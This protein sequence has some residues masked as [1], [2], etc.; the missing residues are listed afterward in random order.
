MGARKVLF[1]EVVNLPDEPLLKAT[2]WAGFGSVYWVQLTDFDARDHMIS[3]I[4]LSRHL[5]R[6][7]TP[8]FL[9]LVGNQ[10]GQA[11]ME[12]TTGLFTPE[13]LIQNVFLATGVEVL[14][15]QYSGDNTAI[16]F[17]SEAS[18][19]IGIETGI[20]MSTGFANTADDQNNSG[21]TSG[22]T[23]Q[24]NFSD[25]DLASLVDPLSVGDLSIF[26][27]TFIPLADSLEFSYV[28]ASEEYEEYVCTQFNDVFGFFISGPGFAGPFTDGAENIAL[29][30]GTNDFVAIGTVNNG[31]P[32]IPPATC[33][34]QN[35]NLFNVTPPNDQPQFDGYTDVFVARA[36]VVPCDTYKIRITIADASDFIFDSGVFL[37]AKSFGTPTVD[38]AIETVAPN[39]TIAE[40]CS[41]GN[42]VFT[43]RNPAATDLDIPIQFIGTATP[44]VD[45]SMTPPTIQIPQGETEVSTQFDVF[46]D[47]VLE[48]RES[49][50]MVIQRD[51]CK[52]DTIW[53]FIT[54]DTLPKPDLGPDLLV[55][56]NDDV[57]LDGTLPV[58]LPEPK[59]F[60][61][62][63]S[64]F[65]PSPPDNSSPVTPVYSPLTV[66]GVFPKDLGPGMI[67]SVCVNI[68]HKWIDDVDIYLIAPSGRFV[69]LSS[70]NG[71]DGDNYTETCFSPTATQRIDY[72][73]PFGAPA[74]A[75][76]FTGS[77]LPEG[78][79]RD[80]WGA[81]ENL[82]NGEWRLLVVDDAP[83]PNGA[84]LNWRITFNP[85]YKIN[86]N[87]TPGAAVACDTCA[88][89]NTTVDQTEF[90]I[91]EV[92]DSYGCIRSDSIQLDLQPD[93]ESPQLTCADIGFNDLT[94]GWDDQSQNEIFAI[95]IDGSPFDT[96]GGGLFS[97]QVAGLGLTDSVTLVLQAIGPCNT[98]MDTIGCR[99]QDC[100]PPALQ[101]DQVLNPACQ[102]DSLGSF[103]VAITNG[104]DPVT[105]TLN[106]APVPVGLQSGLP[107]GSYLVEVSDTLGCTDELMVVLSEPDA[108]LVDAFDLDTVDCANAQN[109]QIAPTVIG[110][111]YPYSYNW[112]DG[113]MDSLRT[114]LAGGSYQVTITDGNGCVTESQV[115]LF[116]FSP[117]TLDSVPQNP[118][119]ANVSNGQIELITGGG[120]GGFD[121]LWNQPG[122]SGPLVTGLGEGTYVVT[123]SDANGCTRVA[124]IPLA[125]PTNLLVDITIEPTTCFGG[126]DG[127]VTLSV[128]G[129]TPPYDYLWS[130]GGPNV[131]VR[132]D[133]SAGMYTVTI[134][135]QG[136]CSEVRD[137]EV[138][139]PSQIETTITENPPSCAGELDG[140][141]SATALGGAGG[142]MFEWSTG[143]TGPL[144]PNL[145]AG[146][147]FLTTTDADAC[148]R[149]DTVS[150][151]DP[152]AITLD[153]S[154]KDVNCFGGTNGTA[155]ASASGGTPPIMYQWDD[156]NNSTFN[157]VTDLPAGTYTV[158]ATDQNG[159]T[160]VDSV[161]VAE[162]PPVNSI[163]ITTDI[164]CFG[165]ADGTA[166][167]TPLGGNSPYTFL[168]NDPQAQNG[169]TASGLEEG[170]YIVTVTDN[171][172]C[173]VLDT[174]VLVA[175]ALLTVN[176]TPTNIT[177]FGAADGEALAQAGGGT[178]PYTFAWS[179][180][181]MQGLAQN[182]PPGAHTVTVTDD[183]GCTATANTTI[184]QAPELVLNGTAV[185]VACA[186]DKTGSIDLSVSGGAGPYSYLWNTGQIVEDPD[187]LGPGIYVVTVTDANNCVRTTNIQIVSPPGMSGDW[188]TFDIA[189]FGDSTGQITTTI[190]GGSPD[191]VYQWSNG[192]TSPDLTG[193][194]PGQYTITVTDGNGC[195][196]S[197]TLSIDQPAAPIV[198]SLA[199]D[200]LDCFGDGNG[201][202]YFTVDGGTP[203]YRYSLDGENYNGSSIQIGL[204]A[205]TYEGYVRDKNGCEAYIGQITVTQPDPILVDLGPDVF[206]ELGADTILQAVVVNGIPPLT[207]SWNA[208]D[209]A[210][211]SCLTCPDPM[212][213][214]LEFSRSF[215]VIVT[216]GNG[217]SGEATI[218]VNV[219]KTRIVLVPTAFTPNGDGENDR[220]A[221]LGRPG[222]RI[223]SY[224]IFDRWGEQVFLA[225]DFM[226][227]DGVQ[228]A[229]SWDGTFRSEAM[230]SGVFVWVIEAEFTDGERTLLKGQ[231]TLLR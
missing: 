178:S 159:C 157:T 74:T 142:H 32:N 191:Y 183:N 65:L 121:F 185:N 120:A 195:T 80:L 109:G 231:V 57:D 148:T 59:T 3:P 26:E 137:I 184:D 206:I 54:D 124:S 62:T 230:N 167:V 94:F 48:G 140:S 63:D 9:I 141:L 114:G 95:S 79:W 122:L 205:G 199:A 217:C 43:I 210:F 21:G 1:D 187:S 44:G 144:A 158:T 118:T 42:G 50:G 171:N 194:L 138:F 97:Y 91:L 139:Q 100:V 198:G 117:I 68:N 134:N 23:S 110:G 212:V 131:N 172:G 84:L 64:F 135:D 46:S 5:W 2:A 192:A 71:R 40:G 67:E 196:I 16:G 189:C 207:Y 182:L 111:T 177:C 56:L 149:V 129:G 104:V 132:N 29:V 116:E 220:L 17:F 163:L 34:P 179:T 193:L 90:L 170:T 98:V 216:D 69:E 82:V 201:R 150:L 166:T 39:E 28:F 81:P 31:N 153:M 51:P 107:A 93:L 24:N 133:L 92:N 102:G 115:D 224:Q 96:V 213:T 70:D 168:W 78:E 19:N 89:T 190:S 147:Y 200:T 11:Q 38:V 128:T 7:I 108:L 112:Q 72:G 127:T 20:V 214:G 13:E 226:I 36:V 229:N 143:D 154:G 223:L 156:P 176:V 180:G 169:Q 15:V 66:S 76:P 204:S 221:I 83:L 47:G 162:P 53:F 8:L 174:A 181:S 228:A 61:S 12:V 103:A 186:G 86:Y 130:D 10:M 4:H 52:L 164:S 145:G 123:V 209:S 33:P 105:I 173:T 14:D 41:N 75:A 161:V 101:V 60:E 175:P 136:A 165:L 119:C 211:L 215:R 30:P 85:E 99:T 146:T 49:V 202:V 73:D 155:S 126:D 35:P 18:S 45:F 125:A 22:Q 219:Q 58:I 113:A 87:W 160:A 152:A 208:Q 25:P 27:I 77:F 197:N 106:G 6:A 227:E 218:T 37:Q 203:A 222:T 88:I 55:C 151:V 188:S 225:E